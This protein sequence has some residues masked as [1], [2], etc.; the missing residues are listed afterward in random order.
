MSD[1][2]GGLDRKQILSLLDELSSRAERRGARVEMF[3]VGGAAM[4]LVYNTTRTTK[5]IEG[6]FEPKM[7][8]YELAAEIAE[9]SDLGLAAD[10]LNDAV[11]VFPFPGDRVDET[12]KVIYENAG[13][14]LRVAS[15]RYLFAMKAWSGRES[16]EED[17]RVLWPLCQFADAAEA[18]D[19]VESA[20][21]SATLRPRTQ[22]VVEDIA[23]TAGLSRTLLTSVLVE[24]GSSGERSDSWSPATHCASGAVWVQPHARRGRPVRGHWRRLR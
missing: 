13:L 10:W 4:V 8:A 16:D 2:S 5:D 11:K 18:L 9:D 7:I 12:A 6:I 1:S 24:T 17:L 15:P 14:D 19:Y 23:A 20:Y 3:L 21:P 22:Y